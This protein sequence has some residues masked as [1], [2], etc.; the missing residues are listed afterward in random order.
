MQISQVSVRKTKAPSPKPT[1]MP[2][3]VAQIPI[4]PPFSGKGTSCRR[5]PSIKANQDITPDPGREV[6]L[7]LKVELDAHRERGVSEVSLVVDGSLEKVPCERV[8][9]VSV[10]K[11]WWH[12]EGERQTTPSEGTSLPT[13]L[14]GLP[15]RPG[16]GRW[17]CWIDA[18]LLSLPPEELARRGLPLLVAS[19]GLS[20]EGAVGFTLEV[21]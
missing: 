12:E 3:H 18:S 14:F 5:A 7:G 10:R 8:V 19:A 17:W 21:G 2:W 9:W 6:D 20:Y 13:E 15:E 4:P 16:M 1:K 11:G